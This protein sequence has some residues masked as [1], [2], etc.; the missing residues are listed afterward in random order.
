MSLMVLPFTLQL[1]VQI[2]QF[3]SH[4]GLERLARLCATLLAY[5][6]SEVKIKYNPH[7]DHPLE[8]RWRT[9][10]LSK[11]NF[12]LFMTSFA[13]RAKLTIYINLIFN[14]ILTSD[15]MDGWSCGWGM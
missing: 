2:I 3:P 9:F 7:R 5:Q 8:Q 4:V 11:A 14:V 12:D 6:L 10:F 13:V 1:H 15:V